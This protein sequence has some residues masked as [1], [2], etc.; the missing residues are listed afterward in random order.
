LLIVA[1]FFDLLLKA[2]EIKAK[3]NK[4]GLI[5]LRCFFTAK[6]TINIMK[7]KLPE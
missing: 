6:D 5:K 1:I 4:R 7:R 2:K 3:I